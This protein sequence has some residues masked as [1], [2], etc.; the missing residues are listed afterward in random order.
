MA[1]HD[2]LIAAIGSGELDRDQRAQV[3]AIVAGA[4][5]ADGTVDLGGS[6][7]SRGD[8][9]FDQVESWATDAL[10]YALA[11][12]LDTFRAIT[13]R[14]GDAPWS[15]YVDYQDDSGVFRQHYVP[16]SLHS[17]DRHRDKPLVNCPLCPVP[18][19]AAAP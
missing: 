1:T 6:F 15:E 13:T 9:G 5:A 11:G 3:E 10:S 7:E 16:A 18:E 8:S 19:G 17:D 14:F 4:Y 12:E 2:E